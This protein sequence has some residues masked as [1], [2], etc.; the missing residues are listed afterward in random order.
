MNKRI[1]LVILSVCL[2][3][4]AAPLMGETQTDTRGPY[5][6]N[7]YIRYAGLN[8]LGDNDIADSFFGMNV[9]WFPGQNWGLGLGMHIDDEYVKRGDGSINGFMNLDFLHRIALGQRFLFNTG[10]SL[11][12]PFAEEED[13]FI[14][15][16]G[17]GVKFDL[18]FLISM[19]FSVSLDFSYHVLPDA[20]GNRIAAPFWGFSTT[21]RLHG[22]ASAA[23]TPS[24]SSTAIEM[25]C[26]ANFD[27]DVGV[28]YGVSTEAFFGGGKSNVGLQ[29]EFYAGIDD[30]N[31]RFFMF[32]GLIYHVPFTEKFTANLSAGLLRTPEEVSLFGGGLAGKLSFNYAITPELSLRLDCRLLSWFGGDGDSKKDTRLTK[33][34]IGA[35]VRMRL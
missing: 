12:L 30:K 18:E 27:G 6:S 32:G 5:S 3:F 31:F 21:T 33:P 10:F 7:F 9:R 24:K 8:N 13:A 11:L 17:H 26:L 16:W 15:G 23:S 28:F 29:A 4:A 35:G 1:C 14:T 19:G 34:F 22:S 25:T 20:A 2:L